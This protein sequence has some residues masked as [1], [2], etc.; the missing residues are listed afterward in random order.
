MGRTNDN[1]GVYAGGSTMKQKVFGV[2]FQKTGTSSLGK[3]LQILGY[4]VH[5]GFRV[6]LPGKIQIDTPVT[7]EKLATVAMPIVPRFSAFEDNPWCLL[8]REL[9][10][11]YPGSK[12]I[13][14][15]RDPASWIRSV[16]RHFGET[17]SPIMEIAYGTHLPPKG[18]EAEYIAAYQAHNRAVKDYF[19]DRPDDLLVFDLETAGWPKLCEFLDRREPRLRAYPVRNRA[20]QRERNAQ[21][22]ARRRFQ[23]QS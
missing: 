7:L 6:N 4:K 12:F 14:T 22:K 16:V 21:R 1:F 19:A 17:T 3:A 2:G 13:L 18:N 23:L 20:E 11:A 5:G 8:Y 10:H 15:T 9:D